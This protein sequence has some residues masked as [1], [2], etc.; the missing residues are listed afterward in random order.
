MKRVVIL[1]ILVVFLCSLSYGV[2]ATYFSSHQL[3]AVLLNQE[4]DPVRPGEIVE[5]RFKIENSGAETTDDVF[6]EIVPSFPFTIYSGDSL[7]NVG[8]MGAGQ[9]GADAVIVKFKLKVDEDAIEG[10]NDIGI[11]VG[12]GGE[13]WKTYTN[14]E[15][16][17]KVETPDAILGVDEVYTKPATIV[18]GQDA[19]LYIKLTNAADSLLRNIKVQLDL[20]DLTVVP[21]DSSDEKSV[22]QIGAG[23]EEWVVFNLV[24]EPDTESKIYKLPIILT[25]YDVAG[26]MYTKESTIGL[27][28][29]DDPELLLYVSEADIYSEGQT[30][31]VTITMANH[32][33]AN[34]KLLKMTLM[35]SDNYEIISAGEV[36][37]GDVDSDDIESQ[38]FDIYIKEGGDLI[39]LPVKLEFR[40]ANNKKIEQT[41]DVSLKLFSSREAKRYG[42]TTSSS[43]VWIILIVILG[44][45]GYFFYRRYKRKK[46]KKQ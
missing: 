43:L 38:E 22:Y 34:I 6:I 25:Y 20:D 23:E 19:K 27:K 13:S 24:A 12:V 18:P 36:Y 40:D 26:N 16:Q 14:G 2:Q 21:L 28:I 32:G 5:V 45:V 30:G 17:I 41:Y 7:I 42:L 37:I 3:D 44:G 4:P 39:D 31:T 11:R 15:F 9:T 1:T 35:P 46:K 29:G 33:L 10:D 8:K